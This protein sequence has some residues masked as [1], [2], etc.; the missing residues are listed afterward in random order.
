MAEQNN[1]VV[2]T[3]DNLNAQ[4]LPFAKHLKSRVQSIQKKFTGDIISLQEIW[5]LFAQKQFKNL[6]THPYF[7][8]PPRVSRFLSS[9]LMTLARYPFVATKF[10]LYKQAKHSDSFA[11]KGVA[12]TRFDWPQLGIVDFYNT[13]LQAAYTSEFQYQKTRLAQLEQLIE[14]VQQESPRSHTV[15]LVGDFNMRPASVEYLFLQNSALGLTDIMKDYFS[16]EEIWT[17]RKANPYVSRYSRHFKKAVGIQLDYIFVRPCVGRSLDWTQT[18]LRI[19]QNQE[20]VLSDHDWIEAKMV[21][22]KIP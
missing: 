9:G 10:L 14:W 8:Q 7:F 4:C 3:L 12:L 13:H 21:F 19:H 17:M 1:Q 11:G 15:I 18:T 20:V 22:Q 2:I 16:G 5:A 6:S